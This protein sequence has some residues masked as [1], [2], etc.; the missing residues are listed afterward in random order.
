LGLAQNVVEN[1]K[2]F[3]DDF[4]KYRAGEEGKEFEEERRRHTEMIRSVLGREGFKNFDESSLL[5]IANNLYAFGWWAKKEWLVD[6][7]I[8]SAGG[9]ENL[10]K[11]FEVLLYSDLKLADRFDT[12]KK[13]VKGMGA[14][15]ISEILT[16][17]DPQKYGI[18]NK[19]VRRGLLKL[20]IERLEGG[21]DVGKLGVSNVSGRDYEA[22]IRTLKEM[23]GLLK[24]ENTLRN[25]DL[26]DVDFFLSYIFK[27]QDTA[28][29]KDEGEMRD[30]PE[31]VDMV[32]NIGKGLG[33]DVLKE[34]PLASGTRIDALWSAQIGNIGELKYVFE[35]HV[36]GSIDSL[37]LNLMKAAQ[38]PA[39][40]KV[41][42]VSLEEE[43]EKIKREALTIKNLADK[44]LFWDIREV[45]RANE[46]VDDLMDTMRRL[47]LT[48]G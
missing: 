19:R 44:I 2:K 46:L 36:K 34:V 1:I 13:N 42:A 43:L 16:Y 12:F 31:I 23:V 38:D 18:W 14:A 27:L 37:I 40:Q 11:N 15:V 47:G 28:V 32:L 35:V 22:V 7:W 41:V 21:V 26:L 3:K 48:R 29:D 33:F 24:D 30:H 17:F 39:V 9:I 20:G 10:R 45:V 6:Y 5:T 25:P 4:L 8:E